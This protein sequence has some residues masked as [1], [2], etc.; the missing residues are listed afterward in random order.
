MRFAELIKTGRLDEVVERALA[1]GN[2]GSAALTEVLPLMMTL[3]T[4]GSEKQNPACAGSH[5][6]PD[7]LTCHRGGTSCEAGV[8]QAGFCA[9]EDAD[10]IQPRL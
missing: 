5:L 8:H 3:S 1:Q 4:L 10:Q 9:P 6:T 2:F 7:P